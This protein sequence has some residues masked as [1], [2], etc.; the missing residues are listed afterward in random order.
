MNHDKDLLKLTRLLYYCVQSEAGKEIR[1]GQNWKNDAQ[2]LGV[3]L[4]KHIASVQQISAG[5]SFD[6]GGH[7][8]SHVDHSSVA[9][10][11]RASIET[12]LAFKYIFTEDD[13]NL[14]LFR[15]KLWKVSGLN[16]RSKITARSKA[17]KTVQKEE[18]E[19]IKSLK[20]EITRSPFYVNADREIRKEIDNCSWKPKG[21]VYVISGH[22]DI[23]QRYFSDIYN[24][25]SEHAHASYISVL[26][27][28]DAENLEDQQML[29]GSA[30]QMLCM[31]LAH[32][33]FAYS[34]LFPNALKILESDA[35]TYKIAT[36]W[37]L[38]TSHLNMLYD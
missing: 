7:A 38:K 16:K 19:R 26:Q 28:R 8:F 31:V 15:H 27:T 18:A 22:I 25:L 35:E 9:V 20:Q 23:H 6:F 30:R 33:L 4:F 17:S 2:V 24:H 11:V 32:F 37:H 34:K 36:N 1:P 5:I 12:L 29:A 13:I 3:K 10:L 14:C 21:G